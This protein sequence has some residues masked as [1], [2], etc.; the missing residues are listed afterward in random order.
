MQA[1]SLTQPW[2]QLVVLGSKRVE[3][4]SWPTRYRGEIAIH[5]SKGY[6]ESAQNLALYNSSF[7]KSLIKHNFDAF[8]LPLGAIVGTVEITDCL[9]TEKADEIGLYSH[10]AEWSFGDYGAGR[11]MWLLANP[12][13]FEI[14]IPCKGAL[15]IW[16]VP[17]TIVIKDGTIVAK[18]IVENS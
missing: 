18:R 2:A 10:H 15:K 9:P 13:M 12:R 17:E 8:N 1:I 14:P 4:R 7:A 5:A 6:P 11:Y 3:T 16:T